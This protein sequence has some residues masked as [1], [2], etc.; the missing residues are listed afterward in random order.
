MSILTSKYVYGIPFVD[1]LLCLK[2]ATRWYYLPAI[3]PSYEPKFMYRLADFYQRIF[4]YR[5]NSQTKYLKK[6]SLI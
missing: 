1:F 2:Q 5:T 6:Q 4:F 3:F